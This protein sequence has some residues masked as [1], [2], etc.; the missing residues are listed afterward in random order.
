ME[1]P[2]GWVRAFLR[3]VFAMSCRHVLVFLLTTLFLVVVEVEVVEGWH[4]IH[5]VELLSIMLVL[6]MG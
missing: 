3:E 4:P 1:K 6:Y 5:L 2:H